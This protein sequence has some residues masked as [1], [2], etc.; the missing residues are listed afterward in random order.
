MK[1]A[2]TKT[3][4]PKR[5]MKRSL[6]APGRPGNFDL[7]ANDS[8]NTQPIDAAC[9]HALERALSTVSSWLVADESP[10][11][12]LIDAACFLCNGSI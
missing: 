11:A 7:T 8:P 5:K 10:N 4:E 9:A 1:G 2:K 3:K 6:V 12:K